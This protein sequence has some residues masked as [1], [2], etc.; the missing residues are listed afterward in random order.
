MRYRV[1][2]LAGLAIGYI[3][4]SRAGR[5]RYEQIKRVTRRFADNPAVQ[6]TAGL[7]QAQSAKLYE[8]VKER[9]STKLAERVPAMRDAANSEARRTSRT[10]HPTTR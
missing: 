3:M 5:E 4:G 8:D 2:F 10:S 7:L 1:S 6:G 9:V